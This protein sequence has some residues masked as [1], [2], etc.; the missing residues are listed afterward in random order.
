MDYLKKKEVSSTG[1]VFENNF[2]DRMN[3]LSIAQKN[4]IRYELKV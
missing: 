4:Y 1:P 2:V 3:T